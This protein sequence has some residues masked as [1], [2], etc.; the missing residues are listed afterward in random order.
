MSLR[1]RPPRPGDESAAAVLVNAYDAAFGGDGGWTA[2][3]VADE[4]RRSSAEAPDVW[5]VERAG[6]LVGC[7]TLRPTGRGRLHALGYTHPAHAGE[8][9]GALIVEMTERRAIERA[10]SVVVRNSVLASDP[11]ACRLLEARG[12]TPESR[13]VRMRVDLAGSP[14]PA[15]PP[16]GIVLTSFRPGVDDAAVDRCVE[17][18]FEHGWTHQA[19]WRLAKAADSRFDPKLW[20]VAREDAEV[21][22]VAL[23]MPLTFGMGFVE[24]LAVRAPWRRRGVG[25]ALLHEALR[26]LWV[27]GERSVG[28]SVDTDNPTAIRLYERAGM[29]AVW[30]AVPYERELRA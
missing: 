28:L 15:A 21:C 1:A 30:S 7:A 18:A 4:W 10:G 13:H 20:I 16:T 17:E 2:V 5:V 27:A 8:G 11:A 24:S 12:Y 23:C 9:V 29:R 26:R 3:D 25:G 6:E 22:G 19:E 14:P